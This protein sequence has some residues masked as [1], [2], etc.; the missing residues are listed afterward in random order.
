MGL[1]RAMRLDALDLF[2]YVSARSRVKDWEE[3]R[4]ITPP[5]REICDDMVAASFYSPFENLRQY[6]R[7][8]F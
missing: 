7:F 6:F 3:R 1:I 5:S 2:K 4:E 8:N